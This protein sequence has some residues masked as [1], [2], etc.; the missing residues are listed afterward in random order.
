[1]SDIDVAQS[2]GLTLGPPE[3]QPP[4]LD[5]KADTVSDRP[6]DSHVGLKGRHGQIS[7]QARFAV[8]GELGNPIDLSS[9]RCD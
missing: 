4:R 2:F 9:G 7:E 1:L 5:E 6:T 3:R 8:A